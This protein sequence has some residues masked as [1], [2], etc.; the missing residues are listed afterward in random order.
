LKKG[1]KMN[2]QIIARFIVKDE[3]NKFEDLANQAIRANDIKSA[4]ALQAVSIF[5]HDVFTQLCDNQKFSYPEEVIEV[6]A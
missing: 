6:I 5:L 3:E 1:D 2:A 4:L